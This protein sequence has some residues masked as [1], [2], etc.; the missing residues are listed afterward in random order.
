MATQETTS[1][2]KVVIDGGVAL[3]G[4]SLVGGCELDADR[5]VSEQCVD[6]IKEAV[7]VGQAHK[8][9]HGL[10]SRGRRWRRGGSRGDADW[11]SVRRM[12][13]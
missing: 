9:V 3:F 7:G 8:L 11:L 4:F 10:S 12:R 1:P 6:G 2:L 5:D 13:V